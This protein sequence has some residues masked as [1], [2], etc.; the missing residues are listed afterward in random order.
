M[1]V[2][3]EAR[4]TAPSGVVPSVD[5]DLDAVDRALDRGDLETVRFLLGVSPEAWSLVLSSL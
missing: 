4:P 5:F 1:S 2:Q 3:L